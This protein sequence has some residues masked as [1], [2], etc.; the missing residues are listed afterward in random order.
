MSY[1]AIYLWH[2]VINLCWYSIS[3]TFFKH[4]SGISW[5]LQLVID[6]YT[7]Y[8]YSLP[9]NW[10]ITF[11]LNF[12]TRQNCVFGSYYIRI[13]SSNWVWSK[14]LLFIYHHVGFTKS[15]FYILGLE[16]M[17]LWTI[18]YLGN[19]SM[20]EAFYSSDECL[21][22]DNGVST[23]NLLIVGHKNRIDLMSN[24]ENIIFGTISATLCGR[25]L[26]QFALKVSITF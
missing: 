26:Q 5:V 12:P 2:N 24:S 10:K 4:N 7:E 17:N 3:E 9:R 21:L 13:T 6:R 20:V 14:S 19:M 25:T 1:L 23:N 8:L 22:S 16:W 18:P 15:I 11:R